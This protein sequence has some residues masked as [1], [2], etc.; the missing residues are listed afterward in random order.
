MDTECGSG[1][2]SASNKSEKTESIT[3]TNFTYSDKNIRSIITN[4]NFCMQWRRE[5][6]GKLIIDDLV[7]FAS[8]KMVYLHYVDLMFRS[9]VVEMVK[10][11]NTISALARREKGG[12]YIC[13]YDG[14]WPTIIEIGKTVETESTRILQPSIQVPVAMCEVSFR[15]RDA[16]IIATETAFYGVHLDFD[17]TKIFG[18][19]LTPR[20]FGSRSLRSAIDCPG[21]FVMIDS[22]NITLCH[23]TGEVVDMKKV[24][25][26]EPAKLTDSIVVGNSWL[27]VSDSGELIRESVIGEASASPLTEKSKPPKR[28]GNTIIDI[29]DGQ[30]FITS[31][32]NI[33]D[34]IEIQKSS[35]HSHFMTYS[36]NDQVVMVVG[37]NM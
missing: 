30:A 13:S 18:L 23:Y 22:E 14:C 37:G 17:K 36:V 21:Y 4:V 31:N 24:R 27:M 10:V 35:P 19:D 25:S 20:C 8:E 7:I 1:N 6:L 26:R 29:F 2:F 32:S 15:D 3:K 34:V 12:F 33:C 16:L 9:H 28:P 5:L 11:A